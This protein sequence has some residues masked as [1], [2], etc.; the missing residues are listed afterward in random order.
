MT[1]IQVCSKLEWKSIKAF[2]KVLAKFWLTL[3]DWFCGITEL[4][5][6]MTRAFFQ[7]VYSSQ[8][9]QLP[10]QVLRQ[11]SKLFYNNVIVTCS[12]SNNQIFDLAR[13]TI[14]PVSSKAGPN[15]TKTTFFLNIS[16]T[17]MTANKEK[18]HHNKQ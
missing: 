9:R 3:L 12:Y 10:F 13:L 18:R 14:P 17:K 2:H 8:S 6:F 7:F 15:I 5:S 11:F 1:S 4:Q 16:P